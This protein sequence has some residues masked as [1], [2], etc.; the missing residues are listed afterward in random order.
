[1]LEKGIKPE[2]ELFDTGMVQVC[3]RLI[4]QKLIKKPYY[5]GLVLG[6]P[7]G[8]PADASTLL[9]MVEHLPPDSLWFAIGIGRYQLEIVT[10]AML[11][12]GHARV[13]LEDNLYYSAGVLAKSNAELVARVVRIA[14]ELGREIATPDEAREMLG[15]TG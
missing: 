9:N 11:L 4:A 13:G 7:S 6:M 15:L 3:H 14:R 5:F 10:L 1:M 8:A 2:L 12:G